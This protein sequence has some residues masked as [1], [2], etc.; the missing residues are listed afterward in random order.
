M[1]T[2]N[3]EVK[4]LKGKLAEADF[5]KQKLQKEVTALHKKVGM[6]GTDAV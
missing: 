1:H 6:A 4:E 3:Q 2:F 5:Q